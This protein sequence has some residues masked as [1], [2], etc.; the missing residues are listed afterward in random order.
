MHV[1]VNRIN[2]EDLS[3]MKILEVEVPAVE[4]TYWCKTIELPYFSKEHHIIRYESDIMPTSQGLIHHMEIFR[5]PRNENVPH[6]NAACNSEM[7]PPGLSHCREVIAAW[8]MGTTGL[9][10]PEQAGIRVGGAR[11]REYAVIEMHYNNPKNISGIIDN[12]GFR[13]Y[14]TSKLRPYDVGVVEL[15]LVY[16]PYNI[17][18]PRQ[19]QFTLTGYCDTQC[20]DVS[21]PKPNGIFVF[22]SQLHTHK[23]GIKVVTHHLRNGTR[24]SDLNRDDYYSPH[25]QQIRQLYEQV[26]IKPGDSL[27]TSCTYNTSSKNQV[28]L[29]GLGIRNEMCINYIFYYPKINLELCKSDVLVR[30][31]TSFLKTLDENISSAENYVDIMDTINSVEWNEKNVQNLERF[32]RN[33]PIDMHCNSSSGTRIK[34]SRT[35]RF[36]EMVPQEDAKDFNNKYCTSESSEV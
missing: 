8:A 35:C 10:F 21:L 30:S 9:T 19:S 20:T 16:S 6:Y 12:S 22:A 17:I 28:T 31:F 2:S 5:C 32:Y 15:G 24:L 11:G 25:F 13:L 34:G 29:G 33:S 23:T 18:P 1:S 27:I 36:P 26:Q 3:Q 14:I 7:K 4:T